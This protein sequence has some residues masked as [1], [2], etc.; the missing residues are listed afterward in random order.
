MHLRAHPTADAFLDVAGPLLRA[1]PLV[2]QMPLG[3]ADAL[4]S[5]PRRYG[6][7]VRLVTV[8]EGAVGDEGCALLGAI[9]H[10]PPWLPGLSSMP[11]EVAAFAGAAYA[12]AHPDVNGAFGVD[13]TALAFAAAAYGARAASPDATVRPGGLVFDGG[14]GLFGLTAVADLPRAPGA[15][16]PA[17]PEDAALLQRW[18]EA[19]HDEAVPTDPP[20]GPTAG[21]AA[22]ARGAGHFW[23]HDGEPVAYASFGR[24]VEGWVSVG[25]V[26]TPPELR[27]H[28]YATTLVADMSRLALDE[29]RVGC[30][31]F[32]D[33]AN[34]TSNRIY[35]RIG[36]RR[37]GTMARYRL[38]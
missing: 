38:V 30:T 13:A 23:I 20:L 25:P 17:N 8:H 31:L 29:G 34:P 9:L 2:H 12:A 27:G 33:L 28:G 3:I 7:A 10:T 4:R 1:D 15:R 22:A 18:L 5:D 11:A 21:A 16:R 36:Y 19:F 14:M 26:Y 24:N 35:E 32:T 37:V 6:D